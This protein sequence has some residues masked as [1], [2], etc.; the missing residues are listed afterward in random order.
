VKLYRFLILLSGTPLAL[1]QNATHVQ[2][3][4]TTA[5]QQVQS[6]NKQTVTSE[7]KIAHGA[8]D[9]A[10]KPTTGVSPEKEAAIRKLFEA[11]GIRESMQQMIGSSIESGRPTLRKMLPPG[12][13]QEKLIDL[14][15]QRFSQKMKVDDLLELV[16]PIYDKYFSKE[17]I[18]GLT[19]FY[20]T[21]AGK[22]ALSKLTQVMM[23]C[24]AVGSKFG[25]EAGRQAMA[26]VLAE[27]PDLQK[28]LEEAGA[29]KN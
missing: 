14:F 2:K 27:H 20:E 29:R 17:D 12:E 9:T 16:I 15:V 28:A 13:Y 7:E 5:A 21:P 24:Q 10:A 26:E 3:G 4:T 25:E 1:A 19:K 23:E 22:K 18:E 6:Q 11:S 8:Q